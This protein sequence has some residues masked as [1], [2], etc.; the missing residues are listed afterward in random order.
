MYTIGQLSSHTG[1]SVETLRFYERKHL[2]EPTTRSASGYRLY[3]ENLL[4]RIATIRRAKS[5]GFTI[6]EISEF[7]GLYFATDRDDSTCESVN[8][9]AKEKLRSIETKIADLETMRDRLSPLLKN[10][11]A[12]DNLNECPIVRDITDS[13]SNSH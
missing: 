13:S 12:D 10:C 2:L 3:D 6:Q 5:L 1:L 11:Q 7:L 9:L 8:R 4:E